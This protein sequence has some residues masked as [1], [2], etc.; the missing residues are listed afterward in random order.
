[1]FEDF[2]NVVYSIFEASQVVGHFNNNLH[3]TLK[4]LKIVFLSFY[5]FLNT[6]IQTK[7]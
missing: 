7:N 4:S 6:L 1:M 2:L 5:E 3:F